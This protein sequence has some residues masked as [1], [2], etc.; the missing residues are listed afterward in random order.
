MN[1]IHKL[2]TKIKPKDYKDM[3][4]SLMLNPEI[5]EAPEGASK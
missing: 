5:I 2:P 1:Q 3:V 4:T